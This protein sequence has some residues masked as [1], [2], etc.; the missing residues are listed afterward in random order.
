IT[1]KNTTFKPNNVFLDEAGVEM[2]TMRNRLPSA[3]DKPTKVIV[4]ISR[5]MS[6]AI[7][8]VISSAGAI[9]MFLRKPSS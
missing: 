5:G 8:G 2:H 6:A 3:K 9:D 1:D 7:L 4:Y